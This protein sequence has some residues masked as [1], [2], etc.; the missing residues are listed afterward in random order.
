MREHM[1]ED[2]RTRTTVQGRHLVGLCH[3]S[4]ETVTRT[5]RNTQLESGPMLQR[6]WGYHGIPVEHTL[7][8]LVVLNPFNGSVSNLCHTKLG[9][10]NDQTWDS[11]T[12]P[13]IEHR[14]H[15]TKKTRLSLKIETSKIQNFPSW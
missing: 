5:A 3:A 13:P 14:Q 11:M 2:T 1:G 10:H 7:K 15:Y 12:I 9:A 6:C 8:L 4:P